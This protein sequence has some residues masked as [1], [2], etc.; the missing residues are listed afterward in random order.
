MLFSWD[1]GEGFNGDYYAA[2]GGRGTYPYTV[3]LDENGIIAKIFFESLEYA[4]LEEIVESLL[5]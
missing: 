3:V 1:T 4:D 2:L 5:G